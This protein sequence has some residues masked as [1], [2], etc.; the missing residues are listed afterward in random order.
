GLRLEG[1]RAVDDP[2]P[3][4]LEMRQKLMRVEHR[5]PMSPLPGGRT[6]AVEHQIVRRLTRRIETMPL[7]MKP[8]VRCAAAVQLGEEPTQPVWMLLVDPDHIVT[9]AASDAASSV[10][11]SIRSTNA[12]SGTPARNCASVP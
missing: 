3:V 12:G 11:R 10:A 9:N 1:P 5:V 8:G 2:H 7:G 6:H 4:A